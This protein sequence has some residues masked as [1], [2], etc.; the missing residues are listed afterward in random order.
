MTMRKFLTKVS[1]FVIYA[2][3]LQVVFPYVVDP[4]NVFHASAIR[5]T[6]VE[7]NQNYIKMTYILDNPE[8]FD[9]F[10]FG[11]S[12]VGAIH[13]EKIM[14]KKIYN[15][16]YSVGLPSEHLANLKTFLRNGIHPSI[17]YIGIDN[18]CTSGQPQA[19]ITEPLRCPYEYLITDKV[20]FYSLYLN[21]YETL[22]SLWYY[23][24]KP[25]SLNVDAFYQYGWWCEY[26]RKP[27]INWETDEIKPYVGKTF[28]DKVLPN[29]LNAVKEITDICRKNNIEFILFTNPL[30]HV[31]YRA[32]VKEN[33][34][35][36]FLE[37]LAKITDF[38]NFSGL[39][40]VTLNNDNYLETSHY[41]AEVGDMI[42]NVICNDKK[43]D[44]LYEQGFGM[45]VTNEN[46]D[47][48]TRMLRGQLK[49]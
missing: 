23:F 20:Y 41:K 4:F 21:P 28:N 18:L 26:G 34:Y 1:V 48:F 2:F 17:I 3:L 39:N 6:G 47:E 49:N 43:Y 31:T 15:M 14:G 46:A 38:Y 29:A 11:S 22:C 37:E 13:T 45:K 32:T 42:I 9:G 7:P 16:T 25:N 5:A 12:R 8:K 44:G 33:N 40:D 24:T 35:L 30:H 10:L 27:T 19:H 36:Y